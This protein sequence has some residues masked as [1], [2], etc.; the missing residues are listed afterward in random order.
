LLSL[1]HG[2]SATSVNNCAWYHAT[3]NFP[4]GCNNNALADTN[5]TSVV[6][7]TDGY[8]NCGKTG[9]A[10][11][12]GGAGNVFAKSA[13]NGQDC[14]VVDL[15][16][17]MYEIS[18]GITCDGTDFYTAKQ[19]TA[20]KNFT[21]GNASATDHWGA[22]GIAAMMDVFTH[23]VITGN[24]G[25]TYYGNAANQV[26]AEDTSGAAW[27]NTSTGI[28]RDVNGISAGGTNLFGTDGMYRYIFNELCLIACSHWYS[29]SFAGVWCAFWGN[30]RGD[31]D[32]YLGFRAACYPV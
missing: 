27:L 20:M 24:D 10:G 12:A 9:S 17:L 8:S 29:G 22:T 23:P 6:W 21:N 2:Q 19:A 11:S 18:I 30:A 1:S 25:W 13:H 31:S 5:D 14:G 15:N 32:Y 7:I 16:G 4:K 28:P 3:Y 26:L